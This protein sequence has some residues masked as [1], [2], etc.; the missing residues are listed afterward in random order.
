[1]KLALLT[2]L[3]VQ[4]DA[5]AMTKKKSSSASKSHSGCVPSGSA[6]RGDRLKYNIARR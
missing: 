5:L 3:S 4:T 2:F 6:M 1:M